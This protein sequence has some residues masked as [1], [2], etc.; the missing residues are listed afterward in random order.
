[1]DYKDILNIPKI[2]HLHIHFN[3]IVYDKK[4]QAFLDEKG[5]RI[6]IPSVPPARTWSDLKK[7][8][9]KLRPLFKDQKIFQYIIEYYLES[10]YRNNICY[11]EFRGIL[12]MFFDLDVND[13]QDDIY[14]Y[15]VYT[16]VLLMLR[17]L[18]RWKLKYI[19]PEYTFHYNAYRMFIK[20]I[21][22][23]LTGTRN[24]KNKIYTDIV[25]MDEIERSPTRL[26]MVMLMDFKFI[27][28]H[29]KEL[30]NDLEKY[31]L[32]A[33]KVNRMLGYDFII[34][35]DLYSSEDSVQEIRHLNHPLTNIINN[36]PEFYFICHAGE[37]KNKKRGINNIQYIITKGCRR[38]GHG[39]YLL[40]EDINVKD[41]LFVEVT[42]YSNVILDFFPSVADHPARK[43]I[44]SNNIVISISSDDPGLFGYDD[45]SFDWLLIY[46][47]WKLDLNDLKRLALNSIETA[48]EYGGMSDAVASVCRNIVK[49]Y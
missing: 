46:V 45:V 44:Y 10:A 42:P 9:R 47:M 30:I 20:N 27:L 39:F 38:I 6:Q 4:F 48:N 29:P 36:F 7:V 18:Y 26:K 35:F 41:K 23:N 14:V 37:T 25:S 40:T 34:G 2:A 32:T 22:H 28:G 24:I 17:V 16:R 33:Q 8:Q 1:M 12:G 31:L 13:K 43:W 21:D 11:T 3:S 19:P 15:H 5:V 49:L